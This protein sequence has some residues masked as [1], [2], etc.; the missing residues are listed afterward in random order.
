[1]HK[2]QLVRQFAVPLEVFSLGALA[3][4]TPFL[5]RHLKRKGKTKQKQQAR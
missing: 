5:Y 1:M 3:F 2:P 4:I